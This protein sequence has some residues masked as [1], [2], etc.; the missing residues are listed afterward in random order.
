MCVMGCLGACEVTSVFDLL[1][2]L[3]SLSTPRLL[4]EE[5]G[6]KNMYPH[7]GAW[8]FWYLPGSDKFHVQW[9]GGQQRHTFHRLCHEQCIHV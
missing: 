3:M 7:Q 2:T 6:F 5:Q 9:T 1:M 4:Q 8:G